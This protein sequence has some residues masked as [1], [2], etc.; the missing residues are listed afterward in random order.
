MPNPLP[1]GLRIFVL[2]VAAVL[3]LGPGI[4][5]LSG[6]T[7]KDEYHRVYR[8]VLTMMEND[9]WLVPHLDGRPRLKKPPLVTWLTRLSFE[10]FRVSLVSARARR[11]EQRL[12]CPASLKKRI[13]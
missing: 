12:A 11:W 6:P 10:S 2:A 13:F 4:G 8:T 3:I 1:F 5:S 9:Q 7:E